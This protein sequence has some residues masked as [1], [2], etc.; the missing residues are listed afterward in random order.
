MANKEKKTNQ[1]GLALA[2]WIL[3]FL[4]LLIVFLVKQD[5]IYSNLKTTRFFERI[6]G[7]TPEFIANHEV[8]EEPQKEE[9]ETIITLKT[10]EPVKT[11]VEQTAPSA[12]VYVPKEEP[13]VQSKTEEKETSKTDTV[14][15]TKN[16]EKP[17]TENKVEQP[18]PVTKTVVNQKLYFVYIGED[19]VVS[20]K[21]ITR[22]VE[23]NDS[24]LVTNINLLLKG[25]DSSEANKG[26]KTLIPPGTKLLSAYVRDGVAFLNFNEEFEFNRIGVDGYLAQLMQIVYTATEFS[27]VKSV[28]F[29]IDGQKK[30]YLGSEGVWIGSP[31]SRTS[32]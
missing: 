11:P 30:E 22:E 24:P 26:Y 29:L 18:K 19:G 4:I 27:T 12:T 1:T 7:S 3:G 15:Q 20:R 17:K 9:E 23:K 13:K 31:L 25:P 21:V 32:F 8:K 14:A 2:C 10:E 6:F 5:E 28:Q 16:E